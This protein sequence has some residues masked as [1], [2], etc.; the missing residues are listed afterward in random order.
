[1]GDKF[2]PKNPYL[3]KPLDKTMSMSV[4][5]SLV[6]LNNCLENA[7]QNSLT[8]AWYNKWELFRRLR[9]EA[10]GN[11]VEQWRLSG[12]NPAHIDRQ[13]LKNSVLKKIFNSH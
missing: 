8:A 2:S 9:P 5:W 7:S 6:D 12:K 11:Q 10:F 13:L 3:R 4:N 1:M